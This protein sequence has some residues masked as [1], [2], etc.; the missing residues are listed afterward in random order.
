V[1]TGTGG[2]SVAE[3]VG[4]IGGGFSGLLSAYLLEQLLGEQTEIVI[5]ESS[6]RLGGRM[7]TSLFPDAGVSYEAG[8]AE[9]YDIPGNPHL[10]NLIRHLG[11]E[12]RPLSGTPSFVVGDRVIHDDQALVGLLGARGMDRLRRFWDHGTALRPPADYAM[13][14]Q[15]QDNDH[16][17]LHRT[18]EEVLTEIDDPLAQWFTAMQCHSDLATEPSLTSGLFGMDNLLIDHPGYCSMYTVPGGNDRLVQALADRVRSPILRS[19]PVVSVNV[20]EG[21]GV[22]VVFGA[23]DDASELQVDSLLV[24][25]TPPGLRAIGWTDAVLQ[26]AVDDHIRHHDHAATYLRVSLLFRERFWRHEFP[27]DYFVSDAFGGVTIYDQSPH[28]GSAGVGVQSW[29]LGGA[30][31]AALSLRPDDEIV[32]AVL[33]AMPKALARA[34]RLLVRA[35]VDRWSGVSG[36][37]GLPGGVPLRP[38]EQRHSPDPRWP[39][40]QL[41]GDYLYD[42]TLCG[43][44]DAVLYA[45]TRLAERVAPVSETAIPEPSVLFTDT[46]LHAG[47]RVPSS[48]TAGFFLD[49]RFAGHR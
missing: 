49:E 10:R 2:D 13:A 27:D 47:D 45:V 18:F 11:L 28:T 23:T 30:D 16:P 32:A 14:G 7:R 43:A 39:Q 26:A 46:R 42:S 1:G 40:L 12:T 22:R 8:V 4:I 37:S 38:L 25:L 33:G 20:D 9:F 31:A 24:T 41:V 44:L 21:R 19:A 29:L 48:P 35:C 3:R 34:D 15:L 36:V 6:A 5:L 17:W